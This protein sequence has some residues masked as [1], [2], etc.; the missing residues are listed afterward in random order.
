MRSFENLPLSFFITERPR[1]LVKLHHL[2]GDCLA[3]IKDLGGGGVAV[4][5]HGERKFARGGRSRIAKATAFIAVA[6]SCQSAAWRLLLKGCQLSGPAAIKWAQW[7]AC[8]PDVFP[9]DLCN[10]LSQMH[11]DAPYHR[12][13][14]T[15]QELQAAFGRD[16]EDLFVA[17]DREPVASGSIA[18]VRLCA[19][20]HCLAYTMI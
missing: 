4:G 7:S 16:L 12:W 10:V 11:E 9:P 3:D 1:G 5:L 19:A 18:Q 17:I 14:D 13:Q 2:K 15:A 20:A 8:R 6:R